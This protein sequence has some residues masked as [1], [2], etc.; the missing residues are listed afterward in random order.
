MRKGHT[1]I[2]FKVIIESTTLSNL[3]KKK[4]NTIHLMFIINTISVIYCDVQERYSIIKALQS[5]IPYTR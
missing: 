4:E 2:N 3:T 5:Y 1:N